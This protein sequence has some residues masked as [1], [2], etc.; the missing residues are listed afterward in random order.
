[1]SGLL[2]NPLVWGLALVL[3]TGAGLA[4]WRALKAPAAEPAPAAPSPYVAAANGKV[5]VEGGMIQVAAR[6]PGIIR[7]VLVNEGETVV[8]GQ[9]LARQEDEEPRL[10]A[11]RALANLE[12][13]QARIKALE[14]AVSTARRERERLEGLVGSNFVAGQRLDQATDQLRQAEAQLAAGQA[15]V[16]TAR[17]ALA[18]SRYDLELTLVRAPVDGRIA[19]RYANPGAGASTLNVSTLFDLEP[20]APRIVRTEVTEGNLS[21]LAA[22]QEV[23][24]SP[25]ADPARS[26]PGRVARISGV[27]GARRLQSDDP[28]ERKDERVVEVVVTADGAPLLLGQRVLVRFL[29]P[30]AKAGP[31]GPS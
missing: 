4:G 28:S 25:E 12:E 24:I 1:M 31:V 5:D 27:F 30:G 22:G 23:Q 2:R 20:R 6:R 14:V 10:A 18:Q 15:A 26:Y 19:R 21:A 29:K 8:R 9:I 3:A 17:A 11:A 16:N 7:E 13:A